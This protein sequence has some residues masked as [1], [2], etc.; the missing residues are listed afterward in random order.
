MTTWDSKK[1]WLKVKLFVDKA[2]EHSQ[3]SPDFAFWTALS[4][5]CLARSALTAIHPAL[6]AD[7]RDAENLLFAFGYDLTAS[8]RSL[9]AHSVYLRLEKTTKNFG[10]QQRELCEFV[11]LMRNAHLHTAELPYEN[12][13]PSKWLPRYYETVQ[14]LNAPMKKSMSGFLGPEI[15]K[16]ALQLIKTLN[17]KT[18][19]TVKSKISAHTKVFE[20]K[21]DQEQK[22]LKDAAAL[23]TFALRGGEVARRCPSCKASG[24]LTGGKSK[25]ILGKI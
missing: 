17:A 23:A 18:I 24:A 22:K 15:A 3:S 25:G 1:L 10:K 2:N 7:P 8:P 12:L 5:E 13:A 21:S 16:S 19:G 14:I 6:N 9:P 20:E 11:A 4:L